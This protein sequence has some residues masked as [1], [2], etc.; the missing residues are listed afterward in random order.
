M[1]IPDPYFFHPGPRIRVPNPGVKERTG[2]LI[3]IHNTGSNMYGTV[4]FDFLLLHMTHYR[5]IRGLSTPVCLLLN[6]YLSSGAALGPFLAGPLSG[7]SRWERVFYM[8]MG[9]DVLALVLLTRL[10]KNEIFRFRSSNSSPRVP[11]P[12]Y[13]SINS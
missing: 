13:H 11:R 8:L 7:D 3:R 1:F 10:A 5:S 12:G 2:S 6:I 9:A 4:P